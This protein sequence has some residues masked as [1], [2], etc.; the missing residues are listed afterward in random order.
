[1][2]LIFLWFLIKRSF[3]F[4]FC[5]GEQYPV[6]IVFYTRFRT[7]MYSNKVDCSLPSWKIIFFLLVLFCLALSEIF[8]DPKIKSIEEK[9]L[10]FLCQRY[11]GLS[12]GYILSL[13]PKKWAYHVGNQFFNN[14]NINYVLQVKIVVVKPVIPCR[15][16]KLTFPLAW[17]F[18][19][20]IRSL[21]I[22]CFTSICVSAK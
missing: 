11:W 9:K 6:I 14:Q 7:T 5:Y 20:K 3:N 1:M 8:R 16:N 13:R 12:W 2:S 22:T 21:S 4:G 19:Y 17:L 15:S 18:I 10:K